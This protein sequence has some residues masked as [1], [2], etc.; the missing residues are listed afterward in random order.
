ML[1]KR[2]NYNIQQGNS[3]IFRTPCLVFP[4]HN[5]FIQVYMIYY[6]TKNVYR[7]RN[8]DNSFQIYW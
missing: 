8:F 1:H 6:L 2:K 5:I 3:V 7:V 4:H